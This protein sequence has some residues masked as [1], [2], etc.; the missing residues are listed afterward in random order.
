[1][2]SRSEILVCIP[3]YNESS[4]IAEVISGLHKLGFLQILIINDG[5][6]D[7]TEEV[8]RAAGAMVITH[9][10]NR[11]AGAASQSGMHF[12]RQHG[13]GYVLQMDG[14]G[15]HY[16]E[17]ADKLILCMEEGNFDL[18]IGSRFLLK[19]HEIPRK[20]I[21]YN[22]ISNLFTNWFCIGNFTDSQSGFR[23]L[24]RK[25]I[26]ELQLTLDGFGYCS[27]MI[28][29]AEKGGLRI[30]EV[31]IRVRYTEYSMS[32]GQSFTNGIDTALHLLYKFF[33]SRS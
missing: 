17:D 2:I 24:N 29:M 3:A 5:S 30:G 16:L 32:K 18:V 20:R 10:I 4:V 12:A 9:L 1:M 33:F 22:K 27:E 11:G 23:L 7:Q 15:Q 19:E 25:A 26:E 6:T 31:A 21:L 14:D 28:F 13:Y 8:A